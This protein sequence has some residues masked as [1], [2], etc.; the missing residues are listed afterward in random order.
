MDFTNDPY[1]LKA[2]G[3]MMILLFIGTIVWDLLGFDSGGGGT[4][5]GVWP[6]Y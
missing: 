2:V 4:P 3:V 1:G 6:D 5:Y